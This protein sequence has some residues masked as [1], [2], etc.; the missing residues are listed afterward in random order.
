[1]AHVAEKLLARA[2]STETAVASMDIVAE[3]PH[4]A[5]RAA[6]RFSVLARVRQ[7]RAAHLRRLLSRSRKMAN[8]VAPRARHARDRLS[9]AV[10]AL[11]D[12][13]GYDMNFHSIS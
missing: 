8:V 11:M 9:V 6:I 4:T 3:L 1:M 10:A 13:G 5:M 2:P 12:V 7:H